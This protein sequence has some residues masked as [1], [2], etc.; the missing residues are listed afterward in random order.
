M[1]GHVEPLK[2]CFILT[3]PSDPRHKYITKLHRRF[4]D[5]LRNAS[6]SLRQQGEENTV[7]AVHILVC[8]IY[9]QVAHIPVSWLTQSFRSGLF[10]LMH[11]SMATAET[12]VCKLH[13]SFSHSMHFP[14]RRS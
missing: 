6:A 5:F 13:S 3:D 1:I 9:P 11:W 4:G 12:G 7:D 10:A 8:T 14:S 2:A